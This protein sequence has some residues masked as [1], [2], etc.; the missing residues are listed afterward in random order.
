MGTVPTATVRGARR[1][2]CKVS[3]V[4]S[5]RPGR[6][7]PLF[8]VRLGFVGGCGPSLGNERDAATASRSREVRPPRKKALDPPSRAGLLSITVEPNATART[9]KTT[10]TARIWALVP[11]PAN[12]Q[13]RLP[14]SAFLALFLQTWPVK[15]LLPPPCCGHASCSPCLRAW[16]PGAS[17]PWQPRPSNGACEAAEGLPR[18]AGC[19]SVGRH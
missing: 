6:R 9:A 14:V 17:R 7:F 13:L 10:K 15:C 11:L 5:R 2:P 16:Q 12:A 1:S 8:T 4:F 18:C 3:R 19:P